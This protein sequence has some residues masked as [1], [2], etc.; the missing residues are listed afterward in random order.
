VV[1]LLASQEEPDSTTRTLAAMIGTT[2]GDG[3]DG[4]DLGG[5]NGGGGDGGD[6]GG[7]G[8]GDVKPVHRHGREEVQL[9]V[10]E[11]ASLKYIVRPSQLS[12]LKQ[13]SGLSSSSTTLMLVMSSSNLAA[14]SHIL[15]DVMDRPPC[16]SH[17]PV[18]E[19]PAPASIS[20]RGKYGGDG[21]R[22]GGDGGEGLAWMHMELYLLQLCP[23]PYSTL[24]SAVTGTKYKVSEINL[25]L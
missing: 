23:S 25:K 5:G 7:D 24:C 13:Y 15:V 10:V 8:G 21:G 14:N 9:G 17:V 1:K 3:G 19:R 2:G 22:T 18:V 4:G 12:Y 16:D 11:A 6:V 20:D